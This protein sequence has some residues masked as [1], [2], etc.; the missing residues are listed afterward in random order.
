MDVIYIMRKDFRAAL[1]PMFGFLIIYIVMII[2]GQYAPQQFLP[3]FAII[4]VALLI[5]AALMAIERRED[6][7]HGY[8]ILLRMPIRALDV[9]VGKLLVMY[10]LTLLSCVLM[11]TVIGINHLDSQNGAFAGGLILLFNCIWLIIIPILYAGIYILGFTRFLYIFRI[12]IMGIL[13]LSQIV[14]F[15][16]LKSKDIGGELISQ[17]GV[18]ITEAPWVIIC[19]V[20]SSIYLLLIPV[21][22]KLMRYHAARSD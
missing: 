5:L 8:R 10:L 1:V 7:N 14:V 17:L 11:L 9:A 20:M 16:L 21:I 19:G 15:L 22:A 18:F 13:V 4:A 6:R 12:V 2:L 3:L